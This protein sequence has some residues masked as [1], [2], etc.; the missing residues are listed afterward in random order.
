[1]SEKAADPFDLASGVPQ[2]EGSI[3]PKPKFAD[4]ISK[5]VLVAAFLFLVLMVVIF[6]GSISQIGENKPASQV[7]VKKV[8]EKDDKGTG[9]MPGDDLLEKPKVVAVPENPDVEVV[10]PNVSVEPKAG[11][12][13]QLNGPIVPDLRGKGASAKVPPIGS[14]SPIPK[15]EYS[16]I[17]KQDNVPPPLTPEQ[18]A[19]LQ[20]KQ[21]RRNR[22]AQ[23]RSKGLSSSPFETDNSSL[24]APPSADALKNT[25]ME[26]QKALAAGHVPDLQAKPT[27]APIGEQDEKLQFLK[28]ATKEERGYHPNRPLPAISPNEVKVGSFIPMILETGINSDL[29]GEITARAS[30]SVYDSTTGCRELIPSMTKF[31]GRYDSK[32]ALGQGRILVAW[33]SAIFPD[34]S[35]LNL[36]G[37]QGYDSSGQAGLQSD[38]D[39]HYLRTFGFAFGMSMV[40]AGVALSVPQQPTSANGS[41]AAPSVSQT[42][43]TALAQQYGQLG[44]QMMGKYL[45][46]QPTLRNYPG[47]RFTIMVPHTIVFNKAFTN[48]CGQ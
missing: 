9:S 24:A 36:A 42:I 19:E 11:K 34:G 4:R 26:S 45:A 32:V 13:S 29:P 37:M 14:N 41:V 27:G 12:S 39:N 20:A 31:V 40:T 6:L 2:I 15:Q 25:I 46:V 7:G 8:E 38:V 16:D 35:E 47:E 5:R 43:A 21:D 28:D 48:R 3:R 18:Q 30:E 44:A 10:D 22:L 23:A 17:P 1:M 33:N